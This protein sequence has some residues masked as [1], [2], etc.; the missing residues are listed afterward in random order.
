MRLPILTLPSEPMPPCPD[1]GN[2][3]EVVRM[4]LGDDGPP[5]W[6]VICGTTFY[7]C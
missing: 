1:C 3:G 4:V 5:F 7:L 6:C 2:R